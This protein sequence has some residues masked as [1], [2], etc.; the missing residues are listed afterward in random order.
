MQGGGQDQP[1]KL[2]SGILKTSLVKK[3][4]TP[5]RQGGG[6]KCFF[7]ALQLREACLVGLLRCALL[8][9]PVCLLLGVPSGGGL[10]VPRVSGRPKRT[11]TSCMA[12]DS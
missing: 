7:Y 3:T 5:K 12:E 9:I 1:D 11:R 10:E 8:S 6:T 2:N 4:L